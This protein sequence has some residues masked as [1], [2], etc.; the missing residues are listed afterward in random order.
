MSVSEELA[1]LASA[2]GTLELAQGAGGNA[3][4]KEGGTLWVKA[5]GR[6]LAELAQEGGC[7][8]APTDLARR[9]LAGVG[10]AEAELFD[11]A[12]RPSLETF[13][14]ALPARVV[15]HTHS[16]GAL[17]AACA[18]PPH[19]A[20]AGC[21]AIPYARP[22]RA[23]GERV[24]A[25]AAEAPCLLLRSHGLLVVGDT[26]EEAISRTLACDAA[27]RVLFGDLP[28]LRET[29]AALTVSPLA[30]L[31][32]GVWQRLG[33]ASRAPWPE[34]RYLF[35]DA[36]I[37]ATVVRV[38]ALDDPRAQALAALKELGRSVILEDD[39]G[40]RVAA[41]RSAAQLRGALEI[42][43]AHDLVESAL[44][45]RGIANYL[46]AGEP[47]GLLDLPGEKYRLA[48]SAAGGR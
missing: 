36:V 22:G 15:A 47:A 5:S 32:Q 34:P 44:L 18:S 24:A 46:P 42:L 16:I 14:H 3:S 35:P 37:Y 45:S 23:L 27:G 20:L 39:S 43:A 9:A 21:A 28:A 2:L 6:R 41:A 30:P 33:K 7:A 38:K 17:L 8:R 48:L 1:Q 26:A 19:D 13:F 12:P 11:R 29:L 25:A 31:E 40:Q 10:G 4:V